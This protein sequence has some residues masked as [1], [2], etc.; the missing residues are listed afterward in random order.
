M[1]VGDHTFSGASIPND[2]LDGGVIHL[3]YSKLIR[4]SINDWLVDHSYNN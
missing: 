3:K 1:E 2:H 4:K